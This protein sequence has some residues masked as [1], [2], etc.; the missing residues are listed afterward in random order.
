MSPEEVK[1]LEAIE[2]GGDSLGDTAVQLELTPDEA[3]KLHNVAR[4]RFITLLTTIVNPVSL[5]SEG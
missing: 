2:L 1:V 3:R 5:A 4:T